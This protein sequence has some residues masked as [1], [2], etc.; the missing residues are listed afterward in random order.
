MFTLFDERGREMRFTRSDWRENVLFNIKKAW[1]D[2]DELYSFIVHGLQD[3]FASDLHPAAE[4][5]VMLDRESERSRVVRAI[6]FLESGDFASAR[7]EL[8]RSMRQHGRTA[9]A[10]TNYAK[11]HQAEGRAAE[12]RQALREALADDP[13]F[14]NALLWWAELARERSGEAAYLEALEEL[15]T[16]PGAWRPQMWIAREQLQ[17]GR[18]GEALRLYEHVLE[19]ATEEPGVLMMISGD[20][21]NAGALEEMVH[22]VSHRY[23][24]ERDGFETGMNLAIALKELGRMSEALSTIRRVQG[25]GLSPLAERL[26]ELEDE[27]ARSLPRESGPQP[28]FEMLRVDGVLWTR[29]LFSPDWLLPEREAALPRFIFFAFS[30]ETSKAT[31]SQ[32]RPADEIGR[33]TRGLPLYLSEAFSMR[34]EVQATCALPIA[35]GIGPV[36]SQAPSEVLSLGR[37]FPQDGG[38]R[39][40]IGGS[41]VPG[42]VEFSAWDVDEGREL[43]AIEVRHDRH[44]VGGLVSSLERELVE[45]LVPTGLLGQAAG[46]SDYVRPP[47]GELG[48]AYVSALEH[49]VYQ[50]LVAN[51]VLPPDSLWNERGYFETYFEL[52][53]RWPGFTGQVPLLAICGVT[54]AVR[55]GS[56]AVEPYRK[57]VLGWLEEAAEGSTLHRL[58]PAVYQRL[59]EGRRLDEWMRRWASSSAD[60]RYLAWLDRV[61]ADSG[62]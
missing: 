34:F 17:A 54:A 32:S 18:T 9:V 26:S 30:D 14:D 56:A 42:G 1:N 59:G 40:A 52:V 41:I 28:E 3:G 35:K 48:T 16:L 20:L 13:N 58:A 22:L 47:D 51:E 29:G 49:L 44:D 2:A 60:S 31:Q 4:R 37:L 57:I 24:P 62:A 38:R 11:V 53:E 33:L 36:V 12:S 43:A 55:Y 50:V 10:L 25:L 45:A 5:L 15:A 27:I 19:N 39:I 23:D 8:D 46:S 61:R 6:V 7:R 21:G